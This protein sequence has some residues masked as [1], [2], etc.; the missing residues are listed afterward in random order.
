M[1][2]ASHH[3]AEAQGNALNN[4][5]DSIHIL[6]TS[7]SFPLRHLS[8]SPNLQ[9]EQNLEGASLLPEGTRKQPT[10]SIEWNS[11]TSEPQPSLTRSAS[12][13]SIL[14]GSHSGFKR[15]READAENIHQQVRIRRSKRLKGEDP[16]TLKAN[17][18]T[19]PILEPPIP[20]TPP[21]PTVHSSQVLAPPQ[22]GSHAP[23]SLNRRT[24]L[25]SATWPLQLTDFRRPCYRFSDTIRL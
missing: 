2:K 18:S 3:P 16:E 7:V 1:A 13:S 10:P 19:A 22:S 15:T 5:S 24:G 23:P 14:S 11:P 21:I 25:L 12:A 4:P 9:S 8:P 17:T 20:R 6:E